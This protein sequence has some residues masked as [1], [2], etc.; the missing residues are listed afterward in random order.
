MP[1]IAFNDNDMAL[2][3]TARKTVGERLRKARERA[4]LTQRDVQKMTAIAASTVCS[5]ENGERDVS[6]D[7][8]AILS[9]LYKQP[10]NDIIDDINVEKTADMV[11]P[12]FNA[13]RTSRI[14]F[15]AGQF[16]LPDDFD[17]RFKAMD[18]EIERLFSG[19]DA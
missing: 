5:I 19:E 6:L 16:S 12:D 1:K 2:A 10:V 15:L 4:G 18:G 11:A 7:R 8:I 14:G 9:H 13:K 17:D 3:R